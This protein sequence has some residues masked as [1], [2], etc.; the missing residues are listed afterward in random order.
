MVLPTVQFI[1][2]KI[3]IFDLNKIIVRN[4]LG[5]ENLP[6]RAPTLD[7]LMNKI[8]IYRTNTFQRLQ[9]CQFCF[10]ESLIVSFMFK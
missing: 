2:N 8:S 5:C 1:I 9:F 4:G 7:R 3:I 10:G 6:K